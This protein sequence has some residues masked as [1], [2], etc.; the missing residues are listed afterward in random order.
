MT[1]YDRTHA[2]G[3]IRLAGLPLAAAAARSRAARAAR[4]AGGPRNGN[5]AESALEEDHVG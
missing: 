3:F 1:G 4:G 5:P 2:E